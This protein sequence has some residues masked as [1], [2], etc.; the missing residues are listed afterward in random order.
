MA[1]GPRPDVRWSSRGGLARGLD[2][3]A[4]A[5]ALSLLLA[6]APSLPANSEFE[7]AEW[8]AQNWSDEERFWFHHAT[9]G[10]AT[11][12]VDYGW[13][14]ALEQ[15]EISWFGDSPLLMDEEYLRRFGFIPSHH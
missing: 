8:L 4:I 2:A 1:R 5:A 10:T 6:C 9:Q 12:P 15:P 11:L 14:M 13:L 7:R 3:V